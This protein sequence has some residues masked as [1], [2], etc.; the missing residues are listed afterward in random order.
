MT[1]SCRVSVVI[2]TYQRCASLQRALRALC[3][4]TLA[5][6]QYEVIV[7]IDGSEDGTKETVSQ[8]QT[9]YRLAS[10]WHPNRGRAAACNTGIQMATSPLIILI[11]DD[12]EPVPEFLAAHLRAHPDGSCRAVVGAIPIVVD[13]SPSPIAEYL[14]LGFETRMKKMAQPG[15][16]MRFNDAYTGNF[17]IRR[18]VLIRVGAFDQAFKIYGHEDYELSLRLLRAGVELVFSADAIAYQHYTKDFVAVARDGIARGKTAVLFASK[19]PEV[20]HYLKLSKYNEGSR[21]WRFLRARLFRLNR[22]WAGTT[23]CVVSFIKWCEKRKAARLHY[24]Y[25][26]ALDY[27]YW[28]GVMSALHENQRLVERLTSLAKCPGEFLG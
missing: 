17:S 24:Y 4:Q 21:K 6:E 10:A 20:Y 8:F 28:I 14:R 12:M 15:Y 5:P 18:D 27:F 25:F 23:D 11:D 16:K 26:L 9:P 19:H 3:W 13:N 1:T 22:L 2:P 7:S